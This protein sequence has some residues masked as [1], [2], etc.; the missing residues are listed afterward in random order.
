MADIPYPF[1]HFP[2]PPH[3]ALAADSLSS[4]LFRNL[5]LIIYTIK[6]IHPSLILPI[7][8]AIYPQLSDRSEKP[9]HRK[10]LPGVFYF[11]S[12]PH[13]N[14][15]RF[16]QRDST[17]QRRHVWNTEGF[18]LF[19][20]FY[21]SPS[22]PLEPKPP[23]SAIPQN[24]KLCRAERLIRE[25]GQ[26]DKNVHALHS[27]GIAPRSSSTIE[28]LREKHLVPLLPSPFPT[29][30]HVLKMTAK[31]IFA[32]LQTFAKGSAESRSGWRVTF[33]TAMPVPIV[34]LGIHVLWI[35]FS[36]TESLGPGSFVP[37]LKK[38]WGIRLIVIREMFRRLIF[39]ALRCLGQGWYCTSNYF[40]PLQ[41]EVCVQGGSE[42]VLHS[43]EVNRQACLDIIDTKY[44]I[45]YP[46][47]YC[48]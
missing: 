20:T 21:S 35:F 14:S 28:T 34:P 24:S 3:P 46:F 18:K 2:S 25:D 1:P 43:C 38:Y 8:N 29:L 31:Q 15:E 45:T 44:S 33:L 6:S 47:F 48:Y 5:I 42:A 13:H 40:Q 32:Q 9:R 11:P 26:L 4:L 39:Q 22:Q 17:N 12:Y 30:E 23:R 36:L 41:L 27:T 7:S 37:I 16:A 10:L 19:K